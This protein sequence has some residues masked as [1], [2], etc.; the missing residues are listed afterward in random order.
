MQWVAGWGQTSSNI[1]NV[2]NTS[3]TRARTDELNH[4][5]GPLVDINSCKMKFDGLHINAE[6]HICAG[7]EKGIQK[8]IKLQPIYIKIL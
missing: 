1:L 4:L 7:G 8:F 6:N 5:Q 2:G 3:T